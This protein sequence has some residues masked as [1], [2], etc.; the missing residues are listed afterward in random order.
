MR[1]LLLTL[2]LASCS[3][4]DTAVTTAGDCLGNPSRWTEH[5]HVCQ[6]TTRWYE[7]IHWTCADPHTF[8]GT[9]QPQSCDPNGTTSLCSDGVTLYL[10]PNIEHPEQ[11]TITMTKGDC[12]DTHVAY[13]ERIDY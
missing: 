2:L 3:G 9:C 6:W 12:S 7:D 1:P 8:E 5:C 13:L 10:H 11:S 4:V